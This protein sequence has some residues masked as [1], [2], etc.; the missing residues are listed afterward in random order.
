[1]INQLFV[2]RLG[3]G[4]NEFYKKR[5]KHTIVLHERKSLFIQSQV[6]ENKQASTEAKTLSTL[7][8]NVSSKCL[9][10]NFDT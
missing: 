1:M 4:A 8:K 7:I 3:R 2:T 5:F 10:E 9:E 6:L